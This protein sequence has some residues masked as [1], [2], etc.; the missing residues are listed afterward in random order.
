MMS[1]YVHEG[2][3]EYLM[4]E[5]LWAIF[6]PGEMA[7]SKG[8]VDEI[9]LMISANYVPGWS[10]WEGVRELVQNW[11]DGILQSFESS[12]TLDLETNRLTFEK[13]P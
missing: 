3:F 13:V 11:Y 8:E 1:I 9:F 12:T 6:V 5:S 7:A 4:R 10:L 2:H